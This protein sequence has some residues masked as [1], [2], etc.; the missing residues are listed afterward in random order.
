MS[1]S[2]SLSMANDTNHGD[3]P[4][5]HDLTMLDWFEVNPQPTF[6]LHKTNADI[7]RDLGFL[8]VYWNPAICKVDSGT[9]WKAIKSTVDAEDLCQENDD[10]LHKFQG[11]SISNEFSGEPYLYRGISW[12]KTVVANQYIVVSG[13]FVNSPAVNS[14]LEP[15]GEIASPKRNSFG[16]SPTFDWT[17]VVP[18]L[19]LS[20][21][22]AWARSVAWSETPLGAM[23]SWPSQLRSIA[24][25]VMHDPRPAVVFYGPELIM[26]YNEAEVELLGNFHPCMGVSAR[27]ALESVWSEYFEP[28]I[29]RNL[30]GETVEKI[31]TSIHMV[32]NGFLEETYFSLKFIPIFDAGGATV[33]H[34]EP[35]VET[36]SRP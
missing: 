9:L 16:K 35:L 17:D 36:V 33:G 22:V 8:P 34:Y 6:I 24:N 20:A 31:N 11:W 32:R 4:S 30:V 7:S 3:A 10:L 21:H 19:S 25:L 27:V 29:E 12:T 5:L 28:I 2:P 26:I 14:V 13:S 18:P 15:E 1:V 23:S